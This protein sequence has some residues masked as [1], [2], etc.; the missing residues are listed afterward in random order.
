MFLDGSFGL[1]FC[2]TI[3]LISHVRPLQ[4]LCRL[5]LDSSADLQ[6]QRDD[7]PES[8][9]VTNKSI[10]ILDLEHDGDYQDDQT[11]A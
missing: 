5:C 8:A 3:T 11:N 10:Y 1:S 7:G 6:V 4:Q 9:A 2:S